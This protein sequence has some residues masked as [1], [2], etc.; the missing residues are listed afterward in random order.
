VYLELSKKS[1]N[2][3]IGQKDVEFYIIVP[4]NKFTLVHNFYIFCH[5]LMISIPLRPFLV[6]HVL[7]EPL[8][9]IAELQNNIT[10]H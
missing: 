5:D 6:N 10:I 3:F 9:M 4:V 7:S 8:K 1:V 2:I